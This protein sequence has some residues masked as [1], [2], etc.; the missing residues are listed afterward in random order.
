MAWTAPAMAQD[1]PECLGT[2]CGKPQEE[3]G[4]GGGGGGT[5][6]VA[7]T[8]DGDTLAYTDDADGDGKADH[9]DNCPFDS[10][11]GQDDG[12]GD[13]VGDVCDNCGA[14]S[15]YSQL[16]VDGDGQG[17][18]CDADIDGDGLANDADNCASIANARQTDADSDGAGDACD[19]DD[20]ADGVVDGEDNCPLV[21]NP[22]QVMPTDAAACNVDSDLDNVSD[23]FDNCPDVANPDQSDT[24]GNG[25]GNA[26]DADI[27]GDSVLNAADN[28]SS[29]ANRDQ[30]D[31]D[32]DG[33]GD[34]CDAL[35]CFVVNAANPDDCLDPKAPFAA[36]GGGFI[37]LKAGETARL[38]LY[39]NR[40]GAAIDYV[41][42]VA[43]R[44]DSSRAAVEN[45]KGAVAM[46][47]RWQ[48]AY[49]DG[50]VPTFTAD[51]DGEYELQLQAT[52]AFP[53]RAYP[54]VKTST[55]ALTLNVGEGGAAAAGCAAAPIGAPAAV[56]GLALLGMLRRR[57]S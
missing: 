57:R 53:D 7:Y 5:V 17:D 27:D 39:A 36:H 56:F 2:N 23:S 35:Y 19:S 4:G 34:A 30:N 54:D 18:S 55:S 52:L 6:W 13:G 3:G 11:R 42:T 37:S 10:N 44:P 31:D 51:V 12:D 45:P 16:D 29:V 20:D 38:P 15:N 28:C 50:K 32:G 9:V 48:Y 1:N 49:V 24:D 14:L 33:K 25:V 26:C 21:S 22:N 8:D 47:N 43:K 41:W 46:S 40:N